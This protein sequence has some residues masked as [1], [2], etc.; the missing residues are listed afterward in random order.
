MTDLVSTDI[1]MYRESQAKIP[2]GNI[3]FNIVIVIHADVTYKFVKHTDQRLFVYCVQL[4]FL[5]IVEIRKV[6]G[7]T[8]NNRTL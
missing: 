7:N 5:F 2:N 3:R 8:Q 6:T 4:Q 1:G